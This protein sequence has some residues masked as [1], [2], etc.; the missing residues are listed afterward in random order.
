MRISTIPPWPVYSPEAASAVARLVAD[1]DV[2]D[3][4]GKGPVKELEQHFS[5]LHGGLHVVSF[6]SGTSALYA[7]LVA[8]G[9][10]HGDEVIVPNLTFLA[11]ASP[12]LWLGARPVLVDSSEDDASVDPRAIARAITSRTKVVVVTHLFGN[13]VDIDAIVE[14]CAAHN[15]RLLEDCSH[16][17]ASSVGDRHVGTFGD[18]AIYS[19]GA[20]KLV[21]GGHGGLLV[22]GDDRTRD[23]ALMV[24]HFKPRTRTDLL[25]EGL[26]PGAEFAL[27]GNLRVSPLAAILALDHLRT[28]DEV[29]KARCANVAVVDELLDG[30]LIPVRS[31]APRLNRS[32]FDL[33][34][35]LPPDVATARRNDLLGAL[36]AAGVPATVPSTRPLNRVVR[37][38]T[39]TFAKDKNL[40]V[41]R[42]GTFAVSAPGDDTLPHSTRLHDRMISFPANRLYEDDVTIAQELAKVAARILRDA[43]SAP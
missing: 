17:H 14:V 15:V 36:G 28:I 21:S 41:R 11:S 24:G 29:T 26:R 1:G 20:G 5:R 35:T 42:L 6:N 30:L 33:V 27:G 37:S 8:L 18:A 25:S 22:A 38:I 4:A 31:S 34:Y 23:L 19:I 9:V 13:P 7:A 32:H 16:A 3:Y 43:F 2:Y 10:T 12:A 40:L 39:P